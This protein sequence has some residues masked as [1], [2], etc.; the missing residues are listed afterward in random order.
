[1][2][3]Q[4][5]YLSDVKEKKTN[6]TMQKKGSAQAAGQIADNEKRKEN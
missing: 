3:L 5:K 4:G 6:Y 2:P 1:M